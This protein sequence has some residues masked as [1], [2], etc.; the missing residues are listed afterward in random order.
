MPNIC[1]HMIVAKEVGKRLEIDS[2]EYYRGN[3]LP[4]IIDNKDSH[5]RIQS[6]VYL[7]PDIPWF[8]NNLDLKDDLQFGY[9]V[10]L[11]LDIHYLEDYMTKLFP[12]RDIFGDP[13]IYRDYDYL[14]HSL[15]KRFNLDTNRLTSA[16][17]HF[18]KNV[19]PEKLEYNI[20]CL[21]QD[22]KGE[23]KYLNLDSFAE[24]LS[25]VPDVICEELKTYAD[26]YRDLHV[27]IR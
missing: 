6:T 18:G 23:P 2:D 12:G 3:L 16:L 15:V 5:H 10:H 17:S 24:F 14:N 21:N 7:I 9:L 22:T 19:I 25:T 8:L 13:Q 20:R 27:R 4:D 11:L 26:K 1:A